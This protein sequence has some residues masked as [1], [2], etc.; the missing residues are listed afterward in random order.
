MAL[1][2]SKKGTG[3][4]SSRPL[5]VVSLALFDKEGRVLLCQRPEGKQLAGKW[6]FPGGKVEEGEHPTEA[7][8][9]E[10]KEELS[11]S[12]SASKLRAASF[13]CTKDILM[14]LYFCKEW[15]GKIIP[16]EQQEIVWSFPECFKDFSMPEADI[17][18]CQQ[19]WYNNDSI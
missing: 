12:L 3:A 8:V 10:I 9:R 15:E 4:A 7:L 6:E 16:T 11:L 18:L 2:Q 5:F 17:L 13:V 19:V 1:G 14:L